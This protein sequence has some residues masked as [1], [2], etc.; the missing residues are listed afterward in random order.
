MRS[1]YRISRAASTGPWID[2]SEQRYL[3]RLLFA[4]APQPRDGLAGIIRILHQQRIVANNRL[5]RAAA[6]V[7]CF[8]NQPLTRF[9]ELR[10]FRSHLGRW[11]FEPFGIAVDRAYFKHIGG[12]SVIY[13]N[14]ETWESL[15]DDQR[16]FFQRTDSSKA[17]RDW[18]IE[19]E[20][21]VLGDL[22]LGVL[23][24]DKAFVFV[25]DP[26]SAQTIAEMSTLSVVVIQ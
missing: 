19:A 10:R 14:E 5:T 6:R 4:S 1:T 20:W 7:V 23:P 12:R 8:T 17:N 2:E 3:D 18:T 16:P 26:V 15:S 11:D 24:R 9:S 25:P 21:R 22:D 13:G